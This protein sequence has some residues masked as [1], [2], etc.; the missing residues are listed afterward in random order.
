MTKKELSFIDKIM[1]T[2]TLSL[3]VT[4]FILFWTLV[5]LGIYVGKYGNSISKVSLVIAIFLIPPI[6]TYLLHRYY[7]M[8]FFRRQYISKLSLLKLKNFFGNLSLVL[9]AVLSAVKNH[10]PSK[11]LEEYSDPPPNFFKEPIEY[12]EHVSILLLQ[13]VNSTYLIPIIFAI[14]S[15]L[16]SFLETS[17]F[18]SYKIYTPK[19][20]KQKMF[21]KKEITKKEII[22][23]QNITMEIKSNL[24]K[25]HTEINNFKRIHY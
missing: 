17:N 10:I 13:P 25:M 18:A 2:V 15:F 6:L 20:K 9:L 3:S 12:I 14:I 16:F 21:T 8:Y 11:M 24:E 7:L 1:F 5:T 22:H 4:A 19:E 23:L